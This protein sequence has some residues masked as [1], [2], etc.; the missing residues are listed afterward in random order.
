[1]ELEERVVED[2]RRV[3]DA[4]D[5]AEARLGAREARLHLRAARDVRL[6]GEDLRPGRLELAHR[7][8]AVFRVGA[9]DEDELHLRAAREIA[10]DHAARPE[11]RRLLRHEVLVAGDALELAREK[12]D[13][14][15]ARLA[16]AERLREE[17]RAAPRG[18]LVRRPAPRHPAGTGDVP[19]VDDPVEAL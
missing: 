9:R 15:P 19:R 1:L 12:R 7:A 5:P 13:V 11:E 17:E 14:E 16:R 10:R 8:A 2:A 6:S 18:D 3:E 4:V